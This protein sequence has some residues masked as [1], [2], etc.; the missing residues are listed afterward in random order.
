M[1][2]AIYNAGIEYV[3]IRSVLTCE[4]KRGVCAL[5]YGRNLASGKL[6]AI[7]EAVVGHGFPRR[8]RLIEG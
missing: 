7:G 8:I 1:A 6:V 5:C 3:R 4:S 2:D